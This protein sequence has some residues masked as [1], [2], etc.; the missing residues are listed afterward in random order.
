MGFQFKQF[1]IEDDL[2]AMKVN[3][4]AVLLGALAEIKD[5]K[6]ILDLGTG[7]GLIAIMLAQRT[8]CT[9]QITAV[10]LDQAAAEQAHINAQNSLWAEQIQI[11]Q[12][13]LMIL[14]FAQPFDLIVSNPPYFEHSPATRSEQRDL[15]RIVVHSHIEWL[16]KAKNWL[17]PTGK[18]SFILPLG[19]GKK[20]MEQAQSVGLYCIECWE[21]KTNFDQPAKRVVVTFALTAGETCWKTLVIYQQNHQYTHEFK[22]LTCDFYLKF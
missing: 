11:I 13:D 20:L 12:G 21:I 18:V 2:C 19:A 1:R 16:K 6:R 14:D 9:A 8:A 5:A 4:D 3:T 7:S 22:A 17:T 15:A 10:E